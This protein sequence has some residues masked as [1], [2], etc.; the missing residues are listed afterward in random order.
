MFVYDQ[1]ICKINF[2]NFYFVAK[3]NGRWNLTLTF[4]QMKY[5]LQMLREKLLQF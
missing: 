5:E 4:S 3:Q 1:K 2:T